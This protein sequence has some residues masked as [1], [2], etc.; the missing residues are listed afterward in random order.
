MPD[1]TLVVQAACVAALRASAPLSALVG[2]RIYDRIPD[3]EPQPYVAMASWVARNDG[4][5]CMDAS[6][7]EFMILAYSD[8]PGRKEVAQMA[9]AVTDALNRL[10][11]A[12]AEVIWQD[13][14]YG[15]EQG[16]VSFASVRFQALC[17]G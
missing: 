3:N 15:T 5:D 9:D 4:T 12:G 14:N 10:Q 8:K 6:T 17:D 13:T 1:N 16:L 2:G 7:V 11:P